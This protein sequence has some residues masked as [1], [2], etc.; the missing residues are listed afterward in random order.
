MGDE[1]KGSPRNSKAGGITIRKDGTICIH[2]KAKEKYGLEGR[3]FA[4]P[5][6]DPADSM[7]TV[8]FTDESPTTFAI[9]KEPGGTLAIKCPSF[10]DQNEIPFREGSKVLPISSGEEGKEIKAK[11]E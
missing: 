6:Y 3:N 11:I 9:S 4:A 7:L 10:L 2:R 8:Q 5:S 1:E